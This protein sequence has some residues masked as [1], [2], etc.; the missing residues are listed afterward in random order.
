MSTWHFEKYPCFSY[1]SF[2]VLDYTDDSDKTSYFS[3]FDPATSTLTLT[4]DS[5]VI[6]TT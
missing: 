1:E 3:G 5:M 4:G 6:G 2:Y